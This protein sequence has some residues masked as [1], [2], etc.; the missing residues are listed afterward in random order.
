MRTIR[1]SAVSILAI[2]LLA[3]SA[4]GVGAQDEASDDAAASEE[5]VAGK[6]PTPGESDETRVIRLDSTEVP[7]TDE[8]P[9]PSVEFTRDGVEIEDIPV[10]PGE[11]LVFR[12]DNAT[13][14]THNFFIGSDDEL[15]V[16]DA[17]TAVGI[18]DWQNGENEIEWTVPDDISGLKFGC[19]VPGHYRSMQ[20]TFSLSPAT[21]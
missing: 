13:G 17:T 10:S 21:E 20:G 11:T 15:S 18:P 19:T 16:S 14:F 5:A 7:P 12:I 1:T 3:G 8:W 4:V 9:F 2:G 6:S